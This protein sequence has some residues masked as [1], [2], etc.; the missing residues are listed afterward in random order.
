MTS[1]MLLPTDE[2]TAIS[3]NPFLATIT[4]VMRS[5]IEVPAAKKVRPIT[6]EEDRHGYWI[7][8]RHIFKSFCCTQE[9]SPLVGY[10]WCRRQHWPTKPSGTSRPQSK[11]CCQWKWWGTTSC[12]KNWLVLNLEREGL[13]TK[14]NASCSYLE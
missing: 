13:V 12:L 4:D 14:Y 7:A 1:K 8:Q 2:E 6:W 3:P 5:G 10:R 11:L 9:N